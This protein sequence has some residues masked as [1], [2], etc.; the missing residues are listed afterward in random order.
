MLNTNSINSNKLGLKL[1]I[2]GIGG[3]VLRL[4]NNVNQEYTSDFRW[5]GCSD[6]FNFAFKITKQLFDYHLKKSPS[7]QN[8]ILIHNYEAGRKVR[9]YNLFLN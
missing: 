1:G 8:K 2:N 5:S 9:E 6:N 7:T 3:N 4:N